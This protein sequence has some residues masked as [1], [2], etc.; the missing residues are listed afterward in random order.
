MKAIC[1]KRFFTF[2][3]TIPVIIVEEGSIVEYTV[4]DKLFDVCDVY[5]KP[6][7]FFCHF[8][9]TEGFD[10]MSYSDFEYILC[11]YVFDMAVLF[12]N[13]YDGV[14]HLV[15]QDAWKGTIMINVNKEENVIRVSFP[16]EQKLYTS[17]DDA[18]EAIRNHKWN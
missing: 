8:K 10:K 18:L 16:D 13:E 15:I 6:S 3:L 17:Y 1:T 11:N 14:H 2:G 4:E 12:P 9:V 5:L 7:E